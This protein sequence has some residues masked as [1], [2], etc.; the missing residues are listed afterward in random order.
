MS[1]EPTNF[2][3]GKKTNSQDFAN[4]FNNVF[5]AMLADGRYKAIAQ[6]YLPCPVLSP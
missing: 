2:A 4:A 6:R 3:F 5:N 1:V